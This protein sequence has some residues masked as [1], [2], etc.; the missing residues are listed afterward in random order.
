MD[1]VKEGYEAGSA[2]AAT[3]F[4]KFWDVGWAPIEIPKEAEKWVRHGDL[5]RDPVANPLHTPSGK[6]E[7]YS[8]TI[9]KFNI[10]DC[11]PTSKW[12]E[13][14]EYLGNA[15]A[16]QLHVVSPHPYYRLHS[17]MAN[18]EPLRALY[19]VHPSSTV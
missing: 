19:A 7:M 4:E 10:P 1:Y 2:A 16:G 18:A 15:R 13:P 17:Q 6:I 8:E 5:R 14:S 3:P 11:P 9:E 12:I